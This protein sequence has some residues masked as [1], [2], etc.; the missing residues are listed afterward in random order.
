[1]E[2]EAFVE[3]GKEGTAVSSD[4]FVGFR[5]VGEFINFNTTGDWGDYSVLFHEPGIYRA[6]IDVATPRTGELGVR[7]FLNG[8]QVGE[9]LLSG[10]GGWTEFISFDISEITIAEAGEYTVRV[11]SYGDE[12][13]Q[14]NGDK[15]EFEFVEPLIINN[16]VSITVNGEEWDATQGARDTGFKHVNWW[17]TFDFAGHVQTGDWAEYVIDFPESGNYQLDAVMSTNIKTGT[18]ANIN[19]YIDDVL[20]ATR[21]I[22]GTNWNSF[23]DMPIADSIAVSK[24]THTIKLEADGP[25]YM[26]QWYLDTFTFSK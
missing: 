11:Q 19:V 3:T 14:W 22:I 17:G 16:P 4:P 7:L 20:V 15:L 2:M 8:E 23:I 13:W 9:T 1:M 5:S 12:L 18:D 10:T 21:S 25:R 6:I 26:W 24:G